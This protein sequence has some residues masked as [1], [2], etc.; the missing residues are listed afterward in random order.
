MAPVLYPVRAVR[1]VKGLQITDTNNPYCNLYNAYPE[2]W[3]KSRYDPP[4]NQKLINSEFDAPDLEILMKQSEYIQQ[5]RQLEYIQQMKQS[6]NAN[7]GN[8]PMS[9]YSYY[10][11]DSK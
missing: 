5:M 10:F 2:S 4:S 7:T 8:N 11:D 9:N 3:Y 1:N 6:Y